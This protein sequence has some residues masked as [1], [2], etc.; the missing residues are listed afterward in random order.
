MKAAE[1][2]HADCVRLLFERG[3]QANLRNVVSRLYSS[4]SISMLGSDDTFHQ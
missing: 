2:G 4:Y 1:K 3:A